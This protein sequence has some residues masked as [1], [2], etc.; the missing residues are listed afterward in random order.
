MNLVPSALIPVIVPAL[1]LYGLHKWRRTEIWVLVV[2]AAVGVILS[3]TILGPDISN[4][5][6]QL[7]GGRLH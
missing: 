5:L 2:A 6:S 1:I 7:S 3:G 4:L